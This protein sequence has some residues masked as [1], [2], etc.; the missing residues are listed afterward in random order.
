VNKIG[1]DPN[2]VGFGWAGDFRGQ[3]M[4]PGTYVWMAEVNGCDGR[5][6]LLKGD[7]SLVR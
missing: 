3:G 1:I 2:D 6:V 4:T 7:I 5:S